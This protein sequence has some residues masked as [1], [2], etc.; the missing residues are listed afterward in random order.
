MKT[1]YTGADGWTVLQQP[2][3]TIVFTTPT[4]RVHTTKP[5]GAMLFP[6]LAILTGELVLPEQPPPGPNRGLAMP[7]RKGTRA[8]ARAYRIQRERTINA[9]RQANDP[10]PF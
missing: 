7:K 2:D 1:F 3:G 8:Q 4:G 10:P 9:A 5:F 6:Q